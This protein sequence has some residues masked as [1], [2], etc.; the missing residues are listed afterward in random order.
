[1]R[2]ALGHCIA[3]FV[4]TLHTLWHAQRSD[5]CWCLIAS[6]SAFQRYDRCVLNVLVIGR[7]SPECL[8]RFECFG[9]TVAVL[10]MS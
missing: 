6:M 3:V 2:C 10:W 7:Q 5:R 8:E 9:H 1:M 4:C